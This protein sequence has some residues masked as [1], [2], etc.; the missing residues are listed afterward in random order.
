MRS[1]IE[2]FYKV[3]TVGFKPEKYDGK[4]LVAY[5]TV[6]CCEMV[7]VKKVNSTYEIIEGQCDE[8]CTVKVTIYDVPEGARVEFI[9]K[10]VAYCLLTL[11]LTASVDGQPT[12]D[13]IAMKVA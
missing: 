8:L 6:N 10:D 13:V 4:T 5:V 2:G 9:D 1:V 3:E 12:T 7:T 11:T